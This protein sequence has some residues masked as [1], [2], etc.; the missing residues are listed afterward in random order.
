M[1]QLALVLSLVAFSTPAFA[2]NMIELRNIQTV[3]VSVD[4][5]VEDG[6]LTNPN[7]LKVEAELILRQSGVRVGA[8]RG[9]TMRDIIPF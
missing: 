9:S 1:K 7:A 8:R 4:D 3:V 6:C 2:Q 5:G